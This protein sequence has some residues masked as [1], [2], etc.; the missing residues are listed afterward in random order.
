[1]Y[2][3]PSN[4]FEQTMTRNHCT[5]HVELER[6]HSLWPKKVLSLQNIIGR[7]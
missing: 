6:N 1:M 4:Q 3:I 2:E 5:S 7:S